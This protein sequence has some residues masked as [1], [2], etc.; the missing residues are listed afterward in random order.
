VPWIERLPGHIAAKPEAWR[1]SA[2]LLDVVTCRTEHHEV[3]RL[4]NHRRM[5][6][7]WHLVV[8][9]Q[10]AFAGQEFTTPLAPITGRS[11]GKPASVLPSTRAV[12][13]REAAHALRVARAAGF[14]AFAVFHDRS[15]KAVAVVGS[16][17]FSL[18]RARLF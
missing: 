17:Q 3:E 16:D 7:D 9:M 8:A 14:C 10:L 6:G 18:P 11:L 13:W 4:E 15:G 5:I 1:T 2:R 12:E